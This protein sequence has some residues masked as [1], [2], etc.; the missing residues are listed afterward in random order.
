MDYRSQELERRLTRLLYW[1]MGAAGLL[2][3]SSLLLSFAL[4][5]ASCRP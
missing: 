1:L 4:L 3:A 5:T 2:I